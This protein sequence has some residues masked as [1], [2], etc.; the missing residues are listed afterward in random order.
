MAGQ[1]KNALLTLIQP[2]L[3][4]QGL[5]LWQLSIKNGGGQKTVE[6]LVD[7]PE[8]VA[9]TMDDLTLFTQA[10]NEVLDDV[11]N[12]PIPEAYLLDISSPGLDRP[13]VEQWHFQWAL[14]GQEPIVLALFSPRLGQ[15]K[16]AGKL[17]EVTDQGITIES[18]QGLQQFNYD[19]IAKAALDVQ[20]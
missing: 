17:T 1:A 7:R 11:D 5:L 16:W 10:V 13:L 8:H 4:N 9:V 12:D 19:E 15:K 3:D 20:F 18:D 14:E 2:I 6:V